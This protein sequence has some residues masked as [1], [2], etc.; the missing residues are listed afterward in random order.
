VS[1]GNVM[2]Y[3]WVR[4]SVLSGDGTAEPMAPFPDSPIDAGEAVK[5]G[6]DA[7]AANAGRRL[8]RGKV[9]RAP[10]PLT[11]AQASI[12]PRTLVR[13]KLMTSSGDR[14]RRWEL[15]WKQ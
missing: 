1:K 14:R 6:D 7:V 12:V 4:T 9:L 11:L 13:I 15:Q 5:A 8:T 10:A 3:K 2:V